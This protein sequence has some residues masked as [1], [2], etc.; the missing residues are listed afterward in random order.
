MLKACDSKCWEA[1]DAMVALLFQA[2]SA[3][4][5]ICYN[6]VWRLFVNLGEFLTS[7]THSS[8]F[9]SHTDMPRPRVSTQYTRNGKP[10]RRRKDRE[11][12]GSRASSPRRLG[13]L[14]LSIAT[15]CG[16]W[17]YFLGYSAPSWLNTGFGSVTR[18]S[19]LEWS[20]RRDEVKQAF[21]TSWQ[22]YVEHAM[23]IFRLLIIS[24]SE[25]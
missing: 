13:I 8:S 16:W 14:L 3:T 4:A 17:S 24:C 6:I 11:L 19:D 2:L 20:A 7:A 5:R 25:C 12:A 9:V 22:S 1:D 10:S 21:V 23:G 18:V 15:L